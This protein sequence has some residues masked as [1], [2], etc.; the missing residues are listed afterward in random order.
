MCGDI[1]NAFLAFLRDLLQVDLGDHFLAKHH[2]KD[3]ID[4]RHSQGYRISLKGFSDTDR[5]SFE[6]DPPSVPDPS[7]L[8]TWGVLNPRKRLRKSS[9]TRSVSG[10]RD[11][12]SQSLVRSLVIIDLS[13]AVEVFL[14]VQKIPKSLPPQKLRLHRPVE[15]L[16][17]ALSLGMIGPAVSHGDSESH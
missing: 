1:G 10:R 3:P 16:V 6:A 14:A 15:A 5:P 7:D 9:R 4:G 13:P 11:R 12:H 8:L 17:F 2:F